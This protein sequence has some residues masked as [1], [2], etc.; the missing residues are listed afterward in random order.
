M[1]GHPLTTVI[2]SVKISVHPVQKLQSQRGHGP[3]GPWEAPPVHHGISMQLTWFIF[4]II[5]FLCSRK[6]YHRWRPF[7]LRK[8]KHRRIVRY[9]WL[10]AIQ[11]LPCTRPDHLSCWIGFGLTSSLK[12]VMKQKKTWFHPALP[13]RGFFAKCFLKQFQ[14]HQRKLLY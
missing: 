3:F 6:K 7:L 8:W 4:I 9:P 2:N 11:I 13:E 1:R 5:F 14:I 12:F 10:P